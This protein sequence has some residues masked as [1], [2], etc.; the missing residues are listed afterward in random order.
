MKLEKLEIL[1]NDF[2]LFTALDDVDKIEFLQDDQSFRQSC[3][4]R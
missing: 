3:W 2:D 1:E 4:T